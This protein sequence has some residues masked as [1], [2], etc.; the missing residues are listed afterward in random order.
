MLPIWY[1]RGYLPHCDG[2]SRQQFVTY[3]LADSLPRAVV[4]RLDQECLTNDEDPRRRARID[5]FL[6]AGYGSCVLRRCDCAGIVEE[7]LLHF[8]RVHYRLL[9]WV[10]MPNHVHVLIEPSADIEL[11]DIVH[12]WKSYTATQINRLLLPAQP[13]G[14]LWQREYWDRFI[15]DEAHLRATID[16]IHDNP[17]KA[18]LVSQADDWQFSSARRIA[19]G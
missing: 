7:N 16:Y 1:S 11:S 14:Q 3:R 6:D 12:S 5:T 9:A 8:D 2:V 10:V 18:G 4:L 17:V 15:R 19:S 13:S